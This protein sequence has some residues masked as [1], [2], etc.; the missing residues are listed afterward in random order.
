M[1]RGLEAIQLE[2]FNHRFG[3]IAEEMGYTLMRSA[4]SANIKE[5]RDYSCALFDSE[6]RMVAQAAHIPVHLGSAP[7][8]V[9]K[10]RSR[11]LRFAVIAAVCC[12]R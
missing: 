8:C 3:A 7:A 1:S 10:V 5:R 9:L 12:R 4:F 11:P 2:V 6:A